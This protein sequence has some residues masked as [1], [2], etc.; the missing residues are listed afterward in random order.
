MT[1]ITGIGL[2]VTLS[3]VAYVALTR[4]Q[5]RE[6]ARAADDAV[7]GTGRDALITAIQWSNGDSVKWVLSKN[8]D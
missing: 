1:V 2:I 8:P 5:T 7:G 3:D 4:H 6:A